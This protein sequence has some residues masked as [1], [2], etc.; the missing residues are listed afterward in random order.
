MNRPPQFLR[1]LPPDRCLMSRCL[2]TAVVCGRRLL[3]LKSP[4]HASS[5]AFVVSP[6][7]KVEDLSK[8]YPLRAANSFERFHYCP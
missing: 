4:T 1:H 3:P 8:R 5:F 2:L 6:V 7:V